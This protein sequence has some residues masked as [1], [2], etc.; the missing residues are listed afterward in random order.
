MENYVEHLV[1]GKKDTKVYMERGV[2]GSPFS[3]LF[4]FSPLILTP[5]SFPDY[6]YYSLF[7]LDQNG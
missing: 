2:A 1:K 5:L 4:C 6:L 7:G 3:L